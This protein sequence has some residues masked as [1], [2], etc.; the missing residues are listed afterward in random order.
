MGKQKEDA[1]EPQAVDSDYSGRP[2]EG[3]TPEELR[4]DIA[5]GGW[6]RREDDLVMVDADGNEWDAFTGE[7][8]PPRKP[9]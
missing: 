6:G 3:I 5:R 9:S 1:E 8:L 7:K 4:A 2:L